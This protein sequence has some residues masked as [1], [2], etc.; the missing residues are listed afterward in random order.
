[1]IIALPTFLKLK[2]TCLLPAGPLL[3]EGIDCVPIWIGVKSSKPVNDEKESSPTVSIT[4][5]SVNPLIAVYNV[6]F[7]MLP[8]DWVWVTATPAAWVRLKGVIRIDQRTFIVSPFKLLRSLT[9]RAAHL[10]P[11]KYLY[12]S[13][14]AILP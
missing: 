6:P 3:N 4:I 9:G 7:T 11:N 5:V 14:V 8:V 2:F 12:K 10:S 13:A 1:M